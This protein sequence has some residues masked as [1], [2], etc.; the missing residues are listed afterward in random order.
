MWPYL[1][2]RWRTLQ[3]TC[4]R[5]IPKPPSLCSIAAPCKLWNELQEA[6][7]DLGE[8]IKAETCACSQRP[9]NS[10]SFNSIF[11][12]IPPYTDKYTYM[13]LVA[14]V[15]NCIVVAVIWCCCTAS[16]NGLQ[17]KKIIQGKITFAIPSRKSDPS[18]V[19]QKFGQCG[20]EKKNLLRGMA[21]SASALVHS[22]TVSALYMISNWKSRFI[23][24]DRLLSSVQ[25]FYLYDMKICHGHL[26]S[27]FWDIVI[28]C[29]AYS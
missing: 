3:A 22:Y 1:G 12:I 15:V 17:W 14:R 27:H 21:Y 23:P 16:I 9:T 18:P 13:Y 10:F 29:T 24:C 6:K 28:K 2:S 19:A 4:I 7:R 8:R 25:G 26:S 11:R 5:K 20:D